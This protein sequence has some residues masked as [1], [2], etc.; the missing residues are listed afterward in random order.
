MSKGEI[1]NWSD[2]E[3]L[4]NYVMSEELKVNMG[5]ID[6]HPLLITEGALIPQ[7]NRER[8]AEVFFET[9]GIQACYFAVQGVLSLYSS[10]RTTGVVVN[11]GEGVTEIVPVYEGFQVG[12]GVRRV[13]VNGR[14]VSESLQLLLRKQGVLLSSSAE[15]EI[16]REMKEKFS[17]VSKDITKEETEWMNTDYDEKKEKYKLPDGQVIKLGKERYRATELLFNPQLIGVE[18]Q[19]IHEV[20]YNSIQRC[21]LDLRTKLN[22]NVLLSGG[23]TLTKGFGDRLINE[24]KK[25]NGKGVKLKIFAPPERKYSVWIGGSILAGLSTFK[26]IWVNKKEWEEDPNIVHVRCL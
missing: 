5:N 21:D 12:N 25:L 9:Y 17:F 10:G 16:V 19:G 7:R 4:W 22:Q 8:M 2:M 13:E 6:E 23:V 1:V 26:K 15:F 3:K 18:S 14:D 20:L 24:S 11:S